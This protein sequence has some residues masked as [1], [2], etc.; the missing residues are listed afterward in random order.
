MKAKQS[1]GKGKR[2]GNRGI[3]DL[4]VSNT[5]AKDTKGGDLAIN[6]MLQNAVS[7]VLKAVGAGV[8]TAARK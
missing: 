8:S 5:K 4:P 1:R 6:N 2:S 7:D 3:K